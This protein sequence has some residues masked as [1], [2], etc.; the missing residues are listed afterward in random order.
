M[1]IFLTIIMLLAA[2]TA[3][4]CADR[5]AHDP[6]DSSAVITAENV[7]ELGLDVSDIREAEH[8][9]CA[10]VKQLSLTDEEKTALSE[11]LGG[12]TF[13]HRSYPIGEAP[14]DSDGG[15]AYTFELSDGELSYV[16]N[17]MDDRFLLYG[18]D[19]Y[20]LID[21]EEFPLNHKED[22]V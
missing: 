5:N 22:L 15:E 13:E 17:G 1:K 9:H 3:T 18:G 14:G 12:L 19:W 10:Q 20:A 6:A 21:P 2:L 8:A 11:W 16:N 4:G 7:S